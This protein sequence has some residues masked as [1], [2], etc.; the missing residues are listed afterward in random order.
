M[1]TGSEPYKKEKGE[2]E[3]TEHKHALKEDYEGEH[4]GRR[5]GLRKSTKQNRKRGSLLTGGICAPNRNQ[6]EDAMKAKKK[7]LRV[8]ILPIP[9]EGGRNQ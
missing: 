6:T 5:G 9:K 1:N 4:R 8:N 3:N 2:R 7:P